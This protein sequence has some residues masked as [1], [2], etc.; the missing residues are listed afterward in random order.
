MRRSANAKPLVCYLVQTLFVAIG[1][2]AR[3]PAT[4]H[5]ATLNIAHGRG[6]RIV[7]VALPN[8][9]FKANLDLIAEVLAR[10]HPDVVA[11]QEVDAPSSR[12][13]SFDQVAHLQRAAGFAHRHHGLHMDSARLGT[14]L[15]YG[16]ALLAQQPLEAAATQVFNV[17]MFIAKGFVTARLE[18]DGRPL[19]V[20]SVHLDFR[21]A[22]TR[23]KQAEQMIDSLS[24]PGLPIVL[25]GDLNCRWRDDSALKLLAERL[26][27]QAYQP[28]SPA[29]ATW[30]A[31]APTRRIDWILISPELEFVTCRVWPDRISDHRGLSAILRWRN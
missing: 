26:N 8:A 9:E 20:V 28:E 27:L 31:H 21:S 3:P 18:L 11:L 10:E 17:G 30:P 14:R 12:S 5:V 4:L 29:W 24:A 1:G 23:R 25:M 19:L 2:C 6:P 22:K 15:R 16:T 13:G 7:Q